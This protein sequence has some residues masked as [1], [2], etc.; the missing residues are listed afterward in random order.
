MKGLIGRRIQIQERSGI[1]YIEFMI[2]FSQG[3][4]TI[5]RSYVYTAT[6]NGIARITPELA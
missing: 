5:N 6:S 4:A 3:G 2:K 1:T